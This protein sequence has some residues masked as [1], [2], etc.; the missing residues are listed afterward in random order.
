MPISKRITLAAAATAL[1]ATTACV[2]DPNTGERRVSRAAIGAGLGVVGGYL[3]G[4]LIGGKGDRTEKIIG[5]GI[6]GIAGGAIGAY[7]DKQEQELRRETAGTGVDVIREGDEIA[8]RMPAG[9]TFPINSY[10]IQPQFQ[11]TL[12]DVARTLASYPSTMIDVYGH[13]DPSGGD[14]INIPLSQNRAQSVA[15]YLAQRGV[16]QARIATQ[17]FGSSR[18]IADNGT[19]AG[20]SANRRVE[21][22]IVPVA[23]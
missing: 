20:R 21:I 10:Q 2:T 17:G 13:T 7:M 5:A 16:N 4:D 12:D 23:A 11:S 18:P 3:A 1:L 6:G 9:I 22:R 14:G 19:E 15:S 8:L